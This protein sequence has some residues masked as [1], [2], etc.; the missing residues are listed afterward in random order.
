MPSAVKPGEETSARA[1]GVRKP[2][3]SD[4]PGKRSQLCSASS[5]SVKS[6]ERSG[7]AAASKSSSTSRLADKLPRQRVDL[8]T[9]GAATTVSTA[10]SRVVPARN[11]AVRTTRVKSTLSEAAKSDTSSGA[12]NRDAVKTTRTS[13]A[14]ARLSTGKTVVPRKPVIEPSRG[15]GISASAA[16]KQKSVTVSTSSTS[17]VKREVLSRTGRVAAS[18]QSKTIGTATSLATKK[19]P[20]KLANG[21]TNRTSLKRGN[22]LSTTTE[23]SED[24]HDKVNNG[25]KSVG[26][27]SS[28][29]LCTSKLTELISVPAVESDVAGSDKVT[30]SDSV[31][32]LE[33]SLPSAD[34]SCSSH[35]DCE[36]NESCREAAEVS[37]HLSHINCESPSCESLRSHC[38]Y[39]SESTDLIVPV[40]C[41]DECSSDLEETSV[42]DVSLNSCRSD[43]S[44]S[45]FHSACSSIIGSV[46]PSLNSLLED[47][48]VGT[49]S[50]SNS[51]SME[52]LHSSAGY[53]TPSE[54]DNLC[55]AADCTLSNTDDSRYVNL[56]LIASFIVLYKYNTVHV[57][58]FF[59]IFFVWLNKLTDS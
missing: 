46:T 12:E 7:A 22:A 34:S 24:R 16:N 40:T 18:A 47:D 21:T 38:E 27:N 1:G 55:E 29:S 45:L 28:S 30:V 54:Q 35:N 48:I 43:C 17:S 58:T 50:A 8:A 53:C 20:L 13:G 3:T 41:V 42:C 14:V 56:L 11:P 52:S 5:H 26:G 32:A 44:T 4:G 51:V 31:N 19:P 37:D 57:Q 36:V 39:F 25:D 59:R 33:G 49:W 15:E 23:A 2:V 10:T 6:V 9:T